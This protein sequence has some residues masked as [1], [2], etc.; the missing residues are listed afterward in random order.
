APADAGSHRLP[1]VAEALAAATARLAADVATAAADPRNPRVVAGARA[2]S[3]RLGHALTAALLLEH[4][5]WAADRGDE[6]PALLAS[7][8]ILR[9]LGQADISADLHEHFAALI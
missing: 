4:A 7:L 2:L 9:R 6:R 8:W 5:A 1:E 3:L